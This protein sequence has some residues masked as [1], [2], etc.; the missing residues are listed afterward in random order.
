MLIQLS[1][2]AKGA[3]KAGHHDLARAY[4]ERLANIRDIITKERI[5]MPTSFESDAVHT[6]IKAY[7]ERNFE[8]AKSP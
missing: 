7:L 1:I 2:F 4:E 6:S 3:E 8:H 5:K